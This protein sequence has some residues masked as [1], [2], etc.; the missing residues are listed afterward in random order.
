[1][2]AVARTCPERRYARYEKSDKV[3]TFDLKIKKEKE[4]EEMVTLS[5]G[6][7]RRK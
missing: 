6:I 4:A 3:G 5:S 1:M 2:H 7:R